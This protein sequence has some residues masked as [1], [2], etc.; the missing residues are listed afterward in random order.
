MKKIVILILFIFVFSVVNVTSFASENKRWLYPNKI[1]TYIPPNHRRTVMMKHAFAEWTRL[2]NKKVLF[3]YVS[4]P[5]KAQLKVSFVKMIPNADREIGLTKYKFLQSG[6]IVGADILIAEKTSDGRQLGNDA[7]YTVMLHE[8]GH[9][10]G[11]GEHSNDPMS[12]MF[13]MEDDRQEILKSDLKKLNSI[14]GW[15]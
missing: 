10:I 1:R 2:T 12:I 14:Y 13:P 8:I 9:A 6:K 5:D 15:K 7:V 4:S 11:I 3:Y